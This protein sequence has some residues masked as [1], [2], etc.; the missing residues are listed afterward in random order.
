MDRRSRRPHPARLG[1]NADELAAAP[2]DAPGPDE[3]ARPAELIVPPVLGIA[4][5]AFSGHGVGV[6]M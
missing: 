3:V 1:G 6:G 2:W 4:G 5:A